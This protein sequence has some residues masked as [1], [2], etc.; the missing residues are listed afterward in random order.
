MTGTSDIPTSFGFP[1]FL[2]IFIPGISGSVLL[3]YSISFLIPS[4]WFDIDVD[5]LLFFLL[6]VGTILGVDSNLGRFLYISVLR[7]F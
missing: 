5:K 6:L 4:D 1:T 3:Y 7:G 2:R